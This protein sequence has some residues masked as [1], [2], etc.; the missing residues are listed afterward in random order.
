MRKV[1][2]NGM[3]FANERNIPAVS[4]RVRYYFLQ[5]FCNNCIGLSKN[6]LGDFFMSKIK[7]LLFSDLLMQRTSTQKIAYVAVLTALSVVCNMFFEFKLA[8]TQ[9]SLTIC[10]SAVIG[11]LI[12]PLFGFVACFLGDLVGFLYNSGGFMYMPWIGLSM[13]FVALISGLIMNGFYIKNKFGVY[14]KILLVALLTFALCTVAINTTAFWL[15]YNNRKVPFTAYLVTRLFVQG[16]IWN[17]LFNYALLFIFYPIILRVK[18][19]VSKNEG[20]KEKAD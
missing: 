2:Q 5:K 20:V 4:L 11:M 7:R 1:L 10:F 8:D 19:Q 15:L 3:S 16:Q 6:V 14:I 17:S 9:F 12:G 13:G 18:K